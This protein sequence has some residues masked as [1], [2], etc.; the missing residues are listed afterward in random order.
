MRKERELQG[1]H[2]VTTASSS[3][4]SVPDLEEGCSLQGR[5]HL[6]IWLSCYLLN[7]NSFIGGLFCKV[8]SAPTQNCSQEHTTGGRVQSC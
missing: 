3:N 8:C 5:Q 6:I 1:I 7:E 4:P 2:A